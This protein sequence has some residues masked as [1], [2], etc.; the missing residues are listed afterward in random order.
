MDRREA[1][2][3]LAVGSGAAI[4]ASTIVSSRVFAFDDPTLADPTVSMIATN[5][6]FTV[7][8]PDGVCPAS[9]ISSATTKSFTVNGVPGGP[10]VGDMATGVIPP[11]NGMYTISVMASST[12]TYSGGTATFSCV[13]DFAT[14]RSTGMAGGAMFM[15]N[16]P[17]QVSMVCMS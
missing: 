12:C 8:Q 17:A 2:K 10:F 11:V 5:G 4:G 7:T 9:A 6:T 15:P 14:T 16:P 1:L 3:K 13:T